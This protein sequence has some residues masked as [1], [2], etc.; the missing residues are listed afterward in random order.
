VRSERKDEKAILDQLK[1][2]AIGGKDTIIRGSDEKVPHTFVVHTG[3]RKKQFKNQ[4]IIHL[5]RKSWPIRAT[6]GTRFAAIDEPSYF[7]RFEGLEQIEFLSLR[8][9][10]DNILTIKVTKRNNL[11][12]FI[13]NG[14]FLG[15]S[16]I[17][18]LTRSTLSVNLRV[19][20]CPQG[21]TIHFKGTKS[22]R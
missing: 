1:E 3:L 14:Q 2:S 6:P 21:P 9:K 15:V 5:L 12:D 20:C 16:H 17:V 18:V 13:V 8:V 10:L 7:K 4:K 22:K 11:K 19:I